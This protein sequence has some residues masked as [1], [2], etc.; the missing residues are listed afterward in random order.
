MSRGTT[1]HAVDITVARVLVHTQQR[2]NCGDTTADDGM[3]HQACW[4][5]VLPPW[6]ATAFPKYQMLHKWVSYVSVSTC[7]ALH[8]INRKQAT[9]CGDAR[10]KSVDFTATEQS[11]RLPMHSGKGQPALCFTTTMSNGSTIMFT[12]TPHPLSCVTADNTYFQFNLDR[13]SK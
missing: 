9:V 10:E 7:L 13:T 5:N 6:H 2:D 4:T 11:C 8:R 3:P 12:K 1:I